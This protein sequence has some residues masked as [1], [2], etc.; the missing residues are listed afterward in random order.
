M[1]DAPAPVAAPVVAAADARPRVTLLVNVVAPYRVPVYRALARAFRLTLCYAGGED[2][3]AAWDGCP[4]EVGAAEVRRSWG[5]VVRRDRRGADRS[6]YQEHYTGL[7]PGYFADLW[8]SR[9]DAVVTNEMGFRTL[10]ALAYGAL[11][12]V[13]VWVVWEGTPH[14]D[15]APGLARRLVRRVVAPWAPRWIALGAEPAAYLEG[16]GVPR[17]RILRLQNA[18]DESLFAAPVAPRF[19]R[20]ELPPGPVLLYAGRL[21]GLKGVDLLIDAAA[22]L[23]DEGRRFTL[24][25]V[26]RGPQEAA[27]RRRAAARALDGVVRFHPEVPPGAMP[28]V[29]RS[30]DLLVFPTLYDQ[31]GLVVNEALWSGLPVLASC[32]AGAASELL[33]PAQV[34][35][36][37]ADG[38]L[39]GALRR[40]LDGGLPAAD[41]SRML[42]IAEVAGRI[43]DDVSRVLAERGGAAARGPRRAAEAAA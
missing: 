33:P 37:L 6:V 28:A 27:L 22:A 23:R 1:S 7:T 14:T 10:C 24:L 18:V 3:R 25:V 16:L 43:V 21:V 2:N 5:V 29:Y 38:A 26:G 4:G 8:R 39:L 36:P 19:A 32:Y 9:P 20:A 13:P 17:A 11:R 35:D 31:W 41:P 12:R 15:R 42:P 34:F 30:A 40:A